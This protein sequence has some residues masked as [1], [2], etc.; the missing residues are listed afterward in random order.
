VGIDG[1]GSICRHSNPK[2]PIAGKI[3]SV[4]IALQHSPLNRISHH[5]LTIGFQIYGGFDK[6]NLSPTRHDPDGKEANN[7]HETKISDSHFSS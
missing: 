3:K 7:E 5:C 1:I 6:A 2:P 4:Q